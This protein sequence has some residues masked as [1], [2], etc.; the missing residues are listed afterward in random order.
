MAASPY[1]LDV[2]KRFKM[3]MPHTSADLSKE[4]LS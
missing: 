2:D 1:K 3:H 4:I